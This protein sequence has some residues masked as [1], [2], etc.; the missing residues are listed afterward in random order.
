[1][2]SAHLALFVL[3]GL[4]LTAL[5][6]ELRR[7]RSRAEGHARLAEEARRAE[8]LSNRLKDEFLTTISHELRTPLN[9]MLGWI[10]LLRTG[11][12][13]AATAARGLESIERNARLQSQVT[14]NLLD[15]SS[16]LT[17]RMQI[18]SRPVR[19]GD[20]VRQVTEAAAV[21]SRAKGVELIMNL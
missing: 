19:V 21:A 7:A 14:G 4:L 3:Q 10:H 16:A 13:D 15:I 6:V 2:A 17:G 5:M 9:A 20:V 12:L 18:D 11:R 1:A 8:A